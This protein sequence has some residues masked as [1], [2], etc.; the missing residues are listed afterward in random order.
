MINQ[1]K[2]FK[3]LLRLIDDT[4]EVAQNDVARFKDS[5]D[6]A[7]QYIVRLSY[8]VIRRCKADRKFLHYVVRTVTG[9][10]GKTTR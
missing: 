7:E 4:E 1:A 5:D 6:P 10:Y 8:A 3:D 9:M 2:A